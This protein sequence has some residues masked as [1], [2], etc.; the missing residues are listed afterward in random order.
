MSY[1]KKTQKY[2]EKLEKEISKIKND[3]IVIKSN[4]NDYIHIITSNKGLA[5]M[6]FSKNKDD[7]NS[8]V[9]QSMYD[10]NDLEKIYL[11]YIYPLMTSLFYCQKLNN[12]LMIGLG[13][14]H[15]PLLVGKLLSKLPSKLPSTNI[16]VV[17][18]D[19]KVVTASKYMSMDA[20]SFLNIHIDDGIN[21]LKNNKNKYD[22]VIIDLDD[23]KSLIKFDFDKINDSIENDG[24]LAINSF[25]LSQTQLPNILKKYFKCSKYFKLP[26]N[27]VF[28][29]S[30]ICDK[31]NKKID[32]QMVQNIFTKYQQDFLNTVNNINYTML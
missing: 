8:Y 22:L 9:F 20:T 18:I 15:I 6:W 14:G 32:I 2:S 12:I 11:T 5:K 23:E 4:I 3:H 10:I 17:E 26:S 28:V 13:G 31:L 29:C 24:V 30:R 19:D 25:T 1:Y 7:I 27:N 21:F 16:Q